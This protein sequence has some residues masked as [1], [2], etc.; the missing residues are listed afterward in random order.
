MSE[1]QFGLVATQFGLVSNQFGLAR[2]QFRLARGQL[3]LARGQFGLA[4][5]QFEW[6]LRLAAGQ[7]SSFPQE[8]DN[9]SCH[10]QLHL[11]S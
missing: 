11:S 10:R 3:G 8:L 4:K 7:C 6:P 9:D 5:G 1:V 2:G